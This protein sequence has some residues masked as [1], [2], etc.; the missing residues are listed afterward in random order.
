M[1][2]RRRR[3]SDDDDAGI[4]GDVLDLALKWP[5][6]GLIF[7]TLFAGLALATRLIPAHPIAGDFVSQMMATLLWLFAGASLAFALLGFTVHLGR[8]LS[9]KLSGTTPASRRAPA[10]LPARLVK[11]PHEIPAATPAEPLCPSCVVPMVR[12]VAKRGQHPGKAFWG[13]RNFPQCRHVRP[14]PLA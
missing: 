11:P 12:R 14:I 4:L 10:V 13:C 9:H 6:A 5:P 3:R 8:T 1:S 2:Y 7:A